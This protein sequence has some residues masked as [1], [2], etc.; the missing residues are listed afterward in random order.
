MIYCQERIFTYFLNTIIESWI[1]RK[2]AQ[3]KWSKCT[4]S[5]GR[6]PLT[7]L[8]WS[9]WLTNFGMALAVFYISLGLSD[10]IHIHPPKT[11]ILY[12]PVAWPHGRPNGTKEFCVL[13]G[14]SWLWQM[15]R[16]TQSNPI[17]FC[18]GLGVDIRDVIW[19]RV[20]QEFCSYC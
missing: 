5:I 9:L 20:D 7:V 12:G 16:P 8:I 18:I 19:D 13:N 1:E 14:M 6:N 17:C 4:N 15:M 11:Y 3:K 10:K 2:Q